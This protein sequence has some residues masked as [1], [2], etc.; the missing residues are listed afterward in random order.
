MTEPDA[1]ALPGDADRDDRA[2]PTSAVEAESGPQRNRFHV[3][4]DVAMR[5]DVYLRGRLKRISRT[6]LQELI[7]AGGVT[8]NDAQPKASTQIRQGDVIDV[9]LPPPAVR[10]IVPEP[11]PLTLL[12]EDEHFVVINKQAD[13][14]VHPARSNLSGTLIN[15][16]AYRFQQQQEA[17]GAGFKAHT[18]R[19]FKPRQRGATGHV[20]GLSAVGAAEFRPG[21]I[22]RLDKHTTGCLVVAKNDRAHWGIARQFEDRTVLKAYLA[23]VHGNLDTGG[24]VIEQP[25]GK[26]PT[27]REAQAVRHDS[28]SKRSVTLFRVR[29]QYRGYCLVELELK[30]GRTHQIRVHLTYAGHPVA[31]DI[32]YGGEAVGPAE[33]AAAPAVAGSRKFLTYARDKEQGER[34]E[35]AAD[36]RRADGDLIMAKPALHAAL[37]SFQHPV[38]RRPVTFTAPLHEPMATLVRRLRHQRIDGPV[39]DS[40]Y[41]ID[42]DE[43][44]GQ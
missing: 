29:E 2:A 26:H 12:Y 35:A 44:I 18:T 41:H 9:I 34:L 17:A 39:A 11:I 31:G 3:R 7:E 19:G 30:T 21:I 23:V 33:L 28:L 16:L 20:D 8:V 37:L 6:K 42:L 40:G 4:R 15:G 32:L 27:I 13:L 10:T 1:E 5:L 43:V 36:K 14:L 38:T 24:G 25:L 22:H